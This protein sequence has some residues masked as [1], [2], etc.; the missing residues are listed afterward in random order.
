MF[1]FFSLSPFTIGDF[2]RHKSHDVNV[3]FSN[4]FLG[5]CYTGI[6][7]RGFIGSRFFCS[8]FFRLL[9]RRLGLFGF[10]F[11][12]RYH[13]S[14]RC[15]RR[16]FLLLLLLLFRFRL[17]RFR[18]D[19]RWWRDRWS[20]GWFIII[21]FVRSRRFLLWCLWGW[22]LGGG[23]QSR[24]H[25][26]RHVWR[27]WWWRC[28]GDALFAVRTESWEFFGVEFEVTLFVGCVFRRRLRSSVVSTRLWV[29]SAVSSIMLFNEYKSSFIMLYR[30]W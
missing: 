16:R 25:V 19:D 21:R 4:L 1:V 11:Y 26:E 7:R 13:S 24:F 29:T 9:L 23:E 15:S 10:D 27:W 17:V 28:W 12:Y 3:F 5:P 2:W 6:S 30:I 22:F 20:D 8:R 18:W 14:I